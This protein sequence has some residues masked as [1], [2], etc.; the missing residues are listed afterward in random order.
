[1]AGG[2][3]VWW[4]TWS[5]IGD[6]IQMCQL[7]FTLKKDTGRQRRLMPLA[8]VGRDHRRLCNVG[9]LR[10]W[11]LVKFHSCSRMKC[12]IFMLYVNLFSHWWACYIWICKAEGYVSD[13][14]SNILI[15]HNCD[16]RVLNSIFHSWLFFTIYREVKFYQIN[17]YGCQP[18]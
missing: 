12:F 3:Q 18:F 16:G 9:S 6:M 17:I 1:M 14:K 13:F 15:C 10:I 2:A 4:R 5:A 11:K 8:W 7:P